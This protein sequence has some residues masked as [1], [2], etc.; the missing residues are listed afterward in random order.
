MVASAISK[1]MRVCLLRVMQF[2]FCE[3]ILTGLACCN[4]CCILGNTSNCVFFILEDLQY[5]DDL[6]GLA[7]GETRVPEARLDSC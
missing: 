1:A 2:R 5:H 4:L 7:Q 6:P 3:C